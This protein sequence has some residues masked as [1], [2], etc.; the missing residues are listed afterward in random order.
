FN[1]DAVCIA[2]PTGSSASK[3]M[4]EWFEKCLPPSEGGKGQWKSNKKTGAITAYDSD[5]EE[6]AKWEFVESW[7][8]KYKCADLD[9]TSDTYL[10]ET[11]TITCEKFNRTL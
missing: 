7:P 2:S 10:E 9:V 8:S 4:Y 11:F 1:F 3:K 6:V 5:G